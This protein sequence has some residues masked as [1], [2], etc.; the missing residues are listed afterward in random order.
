MNF[1]G[2]TP[3]TSQILLSSGECVYLTKTSLKPH[4]TKYVLFK[5]LLSL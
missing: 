1:L 3:E 2:K 5:P 4:K